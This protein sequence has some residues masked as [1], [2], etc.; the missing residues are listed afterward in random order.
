M[1]AAMKPARRIIACATLLLWGA[2]AHAASEQ[3]ALEEPVPGVFVHPGQ[4]VDTDSPRRDDM[5]NIGFI[6][7]D[8]CVAVID[9]GGSVAMGLALRAQISRH[10]ALPICHVINTHGHFDHALGNAA[11][12]ADRPEFIGHEALVTMLGDSE[13]FFR[14]RF[15]EELKGSPEPAIVLPTRTVTDVLELDLGGRRLRLTAHP[16]AHSMADL[17]VEDL[18]SGTLWTGDLLFRERLPVLD[19]SL[20][21]WQAWMQAAA[22]T[23]HPVVIPGHGPIARDWPETLVPQ[24]DYLHALEATVRE[25]IAAGLFLEDVLQDDGIT[26]PEAWLVP[27]P[28][29]RNLGRAW[30][31]LEWE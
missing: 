28:H 29:A 19:G 23:N 9:T 17:T 12:L 20:R 31:E 4:P 13:A 22:A 3:L 25:S 24:R 18:T 11:F 2:V 8:R 6:V 26:L 1:L 10:T 30:R 5:A 16:T 7:G 15:A 21:G 27:R 14:E